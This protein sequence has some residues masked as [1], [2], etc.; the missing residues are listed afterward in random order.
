MSLSLTSWWWDYWMDNSEAES[1]AV[2]GTGGPAIC[3][4]PIFYSWKSASLTELLHSKFMETPQK[5]M[6][7]QTGTQTYTHTHTHTHTHT[8][9]HSLTHSHHRGKLTPDFCWCW[10]PQCSWWQCSHHQT[11]IPAR[12]CPLADC[13]QSRCNQQNTK[14]DFNIHSLAINPVH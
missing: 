14:Q 9:T 1:A 5:G 12:T 6:Q 7:T 3:Q 11:M 4:K 2:V 8:L 10:L 13:S